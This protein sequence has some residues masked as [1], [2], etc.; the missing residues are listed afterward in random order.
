MLQ[1]RTFRL[2]SC[3]WDT[4]FSVNPQQSLLHT[5]WITKDIL[6]I[7]ITWQ[8]FLCG[9]PYMIINLNIVIYLYG[10]RFIVNF[11]W[12]FDN[13]FFEQL[14]YK[15]IL[16]RAWK[17]INWRAVIAMRHIN[18]KQEKVVAKE[19]YLLEYYFN[20]LL[21]IYHAVHKWWGLTDVQCYQY[22]IEYIDQ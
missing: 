20:I 14:L 16:K 7:Y 2:I 3:L 9:Q 22:T 8:I 1:T 15:D 10:N 4:K 17:H 19:R 12:H 13:Y 11:S 5:L 18:K 21:F 6:Q